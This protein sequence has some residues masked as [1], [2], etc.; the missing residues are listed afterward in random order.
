MVS[1]DWKPS[2]Q[3]HHIRCGDHIITGALIDREPLDIQ[4][5]R[6]LAFFDQIW[7]HAAMPFDLPKDALAILYDALSFADDAC[8]SAK[9]R[10]Q[11]GQHRLSIVVCA[12]P[13]T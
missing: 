2:K 3:L 12:F 4:C 5:L 7:R 11:L 1:S 8:Q 6:L 10:I 13:S 9:I